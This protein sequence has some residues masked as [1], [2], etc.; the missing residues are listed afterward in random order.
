MPAQRLEEMPRTELRSAPTREI[1]TPSL[2]AALRSHWQ[3][4]LALFFALNLWISGPYH[5][6]QRFGNVQPTEMPVFAVDRAVPFGSGWTWMYLSVF[7]LVPIPALLL[8]DRAL[9]KRQALELGVVG[10]ISNAI[11]LLWP[12]SVPRPAATGTSVAWRVLTAGD[13]PVNAC[14]SLH[15]SLAVFAALWIVPALR[16][17]YA[18]IAAAWCWTLAILWSTLATKQ[19]VLVDILAGGALA[20]LVVLAGRTFA[21]APAEVEAA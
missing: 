6:I 12:T 15:A 17:R 13:L 11:F 9:L 7:L 16:N 3:L 1:P 10:F 14:P 21:R 20:L 8:A 5:A 18:L 4:K 19:H 2:M